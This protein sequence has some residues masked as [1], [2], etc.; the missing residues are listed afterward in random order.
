[1][2]T[3]N[4]NSINSHTADVAGGE[5]IYSSD[6]LSPIPL[7]IPIPSLSRNHNDEIDT[8]EYESKDV[9]QAFEVFSGKVFHPK[10]DNLGGA[11]SR[12]NKVVPVGQEETRLQRLARIQTELNELENDF[13]IST[14]LNDKEEEER[15][16]EELMNVVKDLTSRLQFLQ[17]GMDVTKR[18]QE[19]SSL[20]NNLTI[21][22]TMDDGKTVSASNDGTTVNEQQK[23]TQMVSSSI[24]Q[25]LSHEQRL[26]RIEQF[27]GSQIYFSIPSSS[28][29]DMTVL[30]RLKLAEDKLNSIDEEKLSLA[31]SRA[32]VIR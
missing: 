14:V 16:E 26:L 25:S 2:A 28:N 29:D 10:S 3:N 7:P 13:K 8:I 9:I 4:N 22:S 1:M 30:E 6:G 27:L 5:A 32:K 24:K 17:R 18:H 20:M 21:Q 12:R 31:S 15:G 11:S 19:L 23:L